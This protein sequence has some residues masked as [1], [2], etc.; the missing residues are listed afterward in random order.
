MPKDWGY[1]SCVRYLCL[2]AILGTFLTHSEQ[3]MAAPKKACL[4][5]LLPT[6]FAVGLRE[7]DD[8]EEKLGKLPDTDA[9]ALDKY[10]RDREFPAVL[11]PGGSIYIVDRHHLGKALMRRGV[12]E[13]YL[14]VIEDW[15]G[16]ESGA[17]WM[18]MHSD[19]HVFLFDEMGE[20][21]L[22]SELPTSLKFLGNDLYRSLAYFVREAG[23]FKKTKVP[24][25]EWHW[26]Q[27]FRTR[28]RL[29]DT[30]EDFKK[31]IKEG[32]ELAASPE[33]AHLPGYI[34]P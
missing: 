23:G 31:S 21:R 34:K 19:N 6:Q 8:K 12:K 15:S 3:S 2:A 17:F 27:F 18:R 5:L 16:L 26:A 28:M 10:L 25:A 4:D 20:E 22:A 32:L 9:K 29:V 33:A 11:G 13:V 7:V 1:N 30:D 24:Y 14:D